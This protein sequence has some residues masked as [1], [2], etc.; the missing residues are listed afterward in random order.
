MM[1]CPTP[2][3]PYWLFRKLLEKTGKF[4]PLFERPLSLEEVN[5]TVDQVGFALESKVNWATILTQLLVIARK[6]R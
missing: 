5:E 6:A 4:P 3:V 2:T 1:S